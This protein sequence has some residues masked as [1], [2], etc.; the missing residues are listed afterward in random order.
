MSDDMPALNVANVRDANRWINVLHRRSIDDSQHINHLYER[1][2]WL[3]RP[4]WRRAFR[5]APWLR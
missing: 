5:T 4:W 1:I 3:S 2:A